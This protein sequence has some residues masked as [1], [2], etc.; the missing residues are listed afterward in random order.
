MVLGSLLD[1]QLSILHVVTQCQAIVEV[2]IPV[3]RFC[4]LTVGLH[5]ILVLVIVVEQCLRDVWPPSIV[6]QSVVEVFY[7]YTLNVLTVCRVVVI[8]ARIRI[9]SLPVEACYVKLGGEPYCPPCCNKSK[10][11]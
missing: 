2:R 5:H 10:S 8:A 4:T 11:R 9:V 6:A 7:L 1:D 3:G